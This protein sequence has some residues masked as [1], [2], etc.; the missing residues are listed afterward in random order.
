M[1]SE[2]EERVVFEIV[3]VDEEAE[4]GA[5]GGM[6]AW[7]GG[8][9]WEEES[10]AKLMGVWRTRW[11]GEKDEQRDSR[12]FRPAP[13]RCSKE[14]CGCGERLLGHSVGVYL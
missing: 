11:G 4:E 6:L 7:G 8:L 12:D 10:V 14:S 1:E 9:L 2:R 3:R 5:G 13:L